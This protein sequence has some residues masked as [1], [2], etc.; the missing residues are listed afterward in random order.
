MPEP[1]QSPPRNADVVVVGAGLAGLHAA[2]MLARAGLETVVLEAQDGVGGRVRTDMVDGFR[3]D[4]GFQV[5]NTS[6]PEARSLLDLAA[7][8]LRTFT[9]GVAVHLGGSRHRLV[10]PRRHPLGLPATL[11]APV[12]S[13]A[14]KA[15]FAVL[16]LRNAAVPADKLTTAPDR[17]TWQALRERGIS[18][19]LTD[20]VLRP[21][22]AGVFLE[23]RLETSARF[24]DLVV[25]SFARG[26]IAVPAAGMAAIPDQ[27]AAGLPPGSVCLSTPVT[28]LRPD[29]VETPYGAVQARAVIVATDPA[30]AGRLLPGLPVPEMRRVTTIYHAAAEPPL[31]EPILVLDGERGGPV[32]NTVVLTAAAP[33]YSADGRALVS[34]SV[35]GD[36]GRDTPGLER[37]VRDHLATLY[38]ADTRRWEHVA[39][40]HL[41]EALPAMTP[42]HDFRKPVRW[43]GDYVCGDH[44]DSSSQQGAL[45][46]GRRA[47]AAVISD[48][49]GAA[50]GQR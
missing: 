14:D 12:A 22:L 23:D 18:P 36:D 26:A 3:C 11:R 15:R 31:A 5:F 42:P 9:Q 8:E 6:Y 33:T 48:L 40:Y 35:V 38:A 29:R 46:S 45:V 37:A 20:R 25:R 17:H 16:A 41:P 43:D 44:R 47:A 30:A 4:R 28:A 27:L 39:T 2:R 1:A 19:E 21:F 34:S 50:Q 24:A 49:L 32:T 10:D 13:I 7:L